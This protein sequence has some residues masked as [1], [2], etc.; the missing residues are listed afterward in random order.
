VFDVAAD[1]QP[2]LGDVLAGEPAGDFLLGLHGAHA[3]LGDVVG[4]PYPA[5]V[6]EPGHISLPAAAEFPQQRVPDVRGDLSL[7]G[8]TGGVPGADQPAQRPLRLHRPDGLRVALGRVLIVPDQVGQARLVAGDV[9]P[10]VVEVVGVPLGDHH[11][12]ERR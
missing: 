7:A 6:A 5:V 3:A 4:G 12:G 8:V 2:V 1:V 11:A 10:A 9:L